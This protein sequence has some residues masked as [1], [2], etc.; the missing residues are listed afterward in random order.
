M[1]HSENKSLRTVS[2]HLYWLEFDETGRYLSSETEKYTYN[3]K[4]L[5]DSLCNVFAV[6]R[7]IHNHDTRQTNHIR[8]CS[9][10]SV[11]LSNSLLC[12][13]PLMHLERNTLY[14]TILNTNNYNQLFTS[15]H[16]CFSSSTSIKSAYSKGIKWICNIYSS[17]VFT[18]SSFG[19]SYCSC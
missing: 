7:D 13:G 14:R 11:R 8:H 16:H 5:P 2:F 12:K 4:T 15:K 17:M 6:N 19:M 9:Y 10:H 3:H 18:T 1:I